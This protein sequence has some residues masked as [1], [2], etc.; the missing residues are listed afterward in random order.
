M[1]KRLSWLCVTGTRCARSFNTL[2]LFLQIKNK[3]Y[4]RFTL[5][6]TEDGERHAEIKLSDDSV[7]PDDQAGGSPSFRPAAPQQHWRHLCYFVVGMLLMFA[8]GRIVI[9]MR[10]VVGVNLRCNTLDYTCLH[11]LLTVLCYVMGPPGY[12]VAYVSQNKPQAEPVSCKL[13]TKTTTTGSQTQVT[14]APVAAAAARVVPEEETELE[15]KDI[16]RLLKQKLTSQSFKNTLRYFQPKPACL[17]GGCSS[18]FSPL[19]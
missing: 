14:S 17:P 18:I 6:S 16:T 11:T 8:I 4:S 2:P 12:M 19:T 10:N 1:F 9:V 15:W 7:D 13:Q 3:Q 5:H